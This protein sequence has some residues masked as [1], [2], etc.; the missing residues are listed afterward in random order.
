MPEG[1]RA[2]HMGGPRRPSRTR[3]LSSRLLTITQYEV[4][5][6]TGEERESRRQADR[7]APEA[8]EAAVATAAAAAAATDPATQIN[9]NKRTYG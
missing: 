5:G 6:L 3:S 9:K 7:K 8:S 2:T 4:S 1:M